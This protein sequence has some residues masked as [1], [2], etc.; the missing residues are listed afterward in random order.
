MS[1]GARTINDRAH[2]GWSSRAPA[3]SNNNDQAHK[4]WTSS[5]S[6][7]TAAARAHTDNVTKK[8]SLIC[9]V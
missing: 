9:S 6:L 4:G 8:I 1:A 7:L 5:C 3:Y 2:K